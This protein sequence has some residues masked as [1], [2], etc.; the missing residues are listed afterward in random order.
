[1]KLMSF[2]LISPEAL[3]MDANKVARGLLRDKLVLLHLTVRML[4]TSVS[5][6]SL[7]LAWHVE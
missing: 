1:M 6:W 7:M 5:I 3:S 4:I 2:P